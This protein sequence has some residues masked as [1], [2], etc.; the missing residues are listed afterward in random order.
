MLTN[1]FTDMK[2][3]YLLENRKTKR[4]ELPFAG[5]LPPSFSEFFEMILHPII[6]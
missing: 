4:E 6:A 2:L 3:I 5:Q 1:I